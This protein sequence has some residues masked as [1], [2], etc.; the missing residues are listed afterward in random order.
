MKYNLYDR[1]TT[2]RSI[3][4]EVMDDDLGITELSLYVH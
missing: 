2:G 3:S 1:L 4:F